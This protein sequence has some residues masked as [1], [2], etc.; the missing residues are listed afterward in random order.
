MKSRFIKIIIPCALLISYADIA[1]AQNYDSFR[2]PTSN[3]VRPRA[4][5]HWM[6]GN[7]TKDGIRKDLTWLHSVGIGGVHSFDA[8]LVTP[9]IVT[10]RLTY[11]SADWK[12][13]FRYATYL[14]D[15]MGMELATA[16]SP[17]W[18]QSG[19]PWVKPRDGMKKL[20]WREIRVD[21]GRNVRMKMPAPFTKSCEFQNAYTGKSSMTTGEVNAVP[22]YYEDISV[23]ACRL[24]DDDRSMQEMKAQISASNGQFTL[25][26]LTNNDLS[27]YLPLVID[28]RTKT[29][30]INISFPKA[31]TVKGIS[32]TCDDKRDYWSSSAPRCCRELEYSDDGVN[33]RKLTDLPEGGVYQQTVSFDGV[34]ARYF[35]VVFHDPPT[36]RA[37]VYGLKDDPDAPVITRVSELILHTA[38]YINHGEEKAGFYSAWDTEVFPTPD[39]KALTEVIDITDKMDAAGNL[40]WKAPK[41]RWKIFRFGFSLT[42]KQNNPASPEATGLEVDKMDAAAFRDYMNYY[43]DLYK[44]A[45]GDKLGEH[46]MGYIVTDSYEAEQNTWTRLLPQEFERR[47][48]YALLPWMPVLTGQVVKSVKESE[49]FLWDWRKTIG[50]LVVENYYDQLNGILAARGMKRYSESQENGRVYLADGM[51]VKRNAD[52]PMAAM[53][54]QKNGLGTD[55]SMSVADIRESASVAHLY[56]QKLVAAESFTAVG[57]RGNA[58]S[59]DPAELKRTADLEFASGLNRIVIHTSV[60]Q[61][62]DDKIPGLGLYV[63]GQWFNRHDTWA[64][65]AKTWIDYLSRTSYMMQQGRFVADVAYYYGEDNNITA[66]FGQIPPA[67]PQGY[68]FDYVNADALQHVLQAENGNL[69]SVKTGATYRVL[70]LDRNCRRM[71]LPVL[72]KLDS[73]SR[74]GVHIYGA[75]PQYK[76][77]MTGTQAEFDQLAAAIWSR[78]NVSATGSLGDM[79]ASVGVAP[80]FSYHAPDNAQLL[81]VHHDT[82]SGAFYWVSNR[83]SRDEQVSLSF[84][85]TGKKPEIWH[86]ETGAKEA[87]SYSVVDGRTVVQATLTPDDAIFVV[88]DAD[89][90]MGGGAVL[91]VVSTAELATVD[92]PWTVQFQPHRGAPASAVFPQLVSYTEN[93]DAGIKYF[94]GTAVYTNTFNISGKLL[95]QGRRVLIDL[96]EVKNMAEVIVNGK[97]LGVLW[98]LPFRTD[99]TDALVKGRNTVVLNVTN[100]W[101]NRII[102]DL[103]P[104]AKEK[105][106]YTAMPFYQ[107]DSPLLPSGLLGPVKILTETINQ[108]DTK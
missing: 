28:K 95:K 52:I 50:E 105:I 3:E 43:L 11:M 76:A 4:W 75:R 10:K 30:Y 85:I 26:Q 32:L 106:T 13:A 33:Y 49:Q 62:V 23:V 7:I 47:R 35:R 100:L 27:D 53:W 71:S 73:L 41:G 88:F 20:V 1:E 94:S 82:P 51:E 17:G 25:A 104:D 18:S 101:P 15:S 108:S 70:V 24:A 67:I 39:D 42:G 107:A 44:D 99:I 21:G 5:W 102:G 61:P 87:A 58:W 40:D 2:N 34:T 91:P 81:F 29:S 79:L 36:L 16:C 56:G 64:G 74:A 38:P 57:M 80:D 59:F 98:K 66:M 14:T 63:F 77:E 55:Q 60:H 22:D 84:R 96:G 9:Q 86:P 46:G 8:G 19:G 83:Q 65:Y 78:G 6:N 97:N 31:Q 54:A 48:G 90:A 103:Q 89:D 37:G 68:N 72:R 45:T 12:D 92:T 93:S 69:V